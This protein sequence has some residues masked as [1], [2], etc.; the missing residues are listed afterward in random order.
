MRKGKKFKKLLS[1]FLC[2]SMAA[3]TLTAPLTASA[4]VT[5]TA[6]GTVTEKGV[7]LNWNKHTRDN[8][9]GT[10]TL[11]FSA[12]A[13]VAHIAK[14]VDVFTNEK[15]Y[16]TVPEDG[17]YI[18]QAWGSDGGKGSD[19][20]V[21]IVGADIK[22]GGHGGNAGYVEGTFSLKKG[23]KLAYNIGSN[24]T[25][26]NQTGTGGGING[27][28]GSHG[29]SGSYGVGG[30]GG[31]TAVFVYDEGEE[32]TYK[33]TDDYI[34]IAGGGGG[35]GAGHSSQTK[36]PDGGDAGN[37]N[38]SAHAALTA[39]QNNGVA[40]TYYAGSNG[41]SNSD[42]DEYIGY[43]ATNEPGAANSSVWGW[44]S[45][46]SGNDWLGTYDTSRAGG[47]GGNGN[48]RG[49]AGGAG[50]AGGSGGV[51]R[52]IITAWDCGGGGG[53]SSFIAEAAGAVNEAYRSYMLDDNASTTGGSVAI[54][55]VLDNLDKTETLNNVTISGSIGDAFEFVTDGAEEMEISGKSFTINNQNLEPTLL[56]SSGSVSVELTVKPIDGFAGGNAVQLLKGIEISNEEYNFNIE[57]K[58]DTDYVNVPWK[59]TVTA[60]TIYAEP[61][62]TLN[63]SD[64]YAD[65]N[66]RDKV[67][68]DD[69]FAY[70]KEITDYS[71]NG[72]TEATFTALEQTTRYT[73]SYTITAKNEPSKVGTPVGGTISATAVVDVS[74][75]AY[76]NVDGSRNGYKKTLKYNEDGTYD[77]VIEHS[78]GA[79]SGIGSQ[80]SYNETMEEVGTYTT[81]GTETYTITEDG[82][83][84]ILLR[85][86][87]GGDGGDACGDLWNLGS[88]GGAHRHGYGGAGADGGYAYAL[89]KFKANDVLNIT[90]GANGTD[91]KIAEGFTIL[92]D[93]P[94]ES[95]GGTAGNSTAVE[96][97]GN[98]I[99]IAS[100]GAGGGGAY[101]LNIFLTTKTDYYGHG[102]A[103]AQGIT[104]IKDVMPEELPVSTNGTNGSQDGRST[105]ENNMAYAAGTSGN[106]SIFAPFAVEN[107]SSADPNYKTLLSSEK[108]QELIA[109][110]DIPAVTERAHACTDWK[111]TDT[112]TP[113]TAPADTLAKAH[114]E[115]TKLKDTAGVKIYKIT[116]EKTETE[117]EGVRDNLTLSGEISKYFTIKNIEVTGASTSE[118]VIVNGADGAASTFEIG[119][120]IAYNKDTDVVYTIKLEPRTGFLGGNDVP[121]L[122]TDGGCP[123]GLKLTRTGITE[124]ATDDSADLEAKDASD[125]ANVAIADYDFGLTTHDKTIVKGDSVKVSELYDEVTP[126]PAD[127]KADFVELKAELEG[128][129]GAT[130]VSPAVTTEYMLSV[131]LAP[132]TENT[133]AVVA[134]KAQ[135]VK[136]SKPATVY[137][138]YSVTY[139]VKNITPSYTANAQYHES[140][141]TILN[142]GGYVMPDAISVKMGGTELPAT[143]YS[144]DKTT[145]RV[146]INENV[147]EDNITI[148]ATATV[149]TYALIYNLYD[150]DGELTDTHTDYYEIGAAIDHTWAEN[151]AAEAN[152][153][154]DAGYTFVWKWN[155]SDEK[156][157]DKMPGYSVSVDGYYDKIQYT[158]TINYV[159]ENGATAES[160]YSK[161]YTWG[162]AYSVNSP[163]IS[164][165]IADQ[166]TVS[167]TMPK[168]NKTVTVTYSEIAP[169]KYP[170][171][172]YYKYENG[173]T[174]A[175]T[176]SGTF[177][178]GASYSVNSPEITGYI[179]SP[180]LV[181][182]TMT[183]DG[184]TV[185]VTYREDITEVTVSFDAQ[186]GSLA[187]SDTSKTVYCG[188]GRNYGT[189]PTPVK[190]N[191][192][193]I[194][195]FTEAEDGTQ[196]TS[197]TVVTNSSN[198][199]LY[200]HWQGITAKITYDANGGKFTE[201]T[202]VTLDGTYGETY[203]VPSEDPKY[204]GYEFTGWYTDKAAASK[205]NTDAV[206]AYNSPR[207]LYAGW[208]LVDSAEVKF[209]EGGFTVKKYT[210]DPGTTL[211]AEKVT[212]STTGGYFKGWK[213]EDD[214]TDILILD[215]YEKKQGNNSFS[216]T[217]NTDE[218]QVFEKKYAAFW[219]SADDMGKAGVSN[220]KA[221]AVTLASGK[222]AIRFLA[223]ID[224]DFSTYTR[225]GF[226][227]T[228]DCPTPTVEA[229]YQYSNQTKIYKKVYAM[230]TD[231]TTGWLDLAYLKGNTF[232]FDNGAG[233]L[234][235]NLVIKSGN[236]EEIY[237][238][239][240]YIVNAD[241]EYVYGQTRAISYNQ[242]KEYD[243]AVKNQE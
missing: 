82:Y 8:G 220:A 28:G 184:K 63:T 23:Q 140:Y 225:A 224:G 147:I 40:G 57:E 1:A 106:S 194:G 116:R 14:N 65:D 195:W 31:Y 158:L 18:I 185:T 81:A 73:V 151:Y 162:Q 10:Y 139:N 142:G 101:G 134:Q 126:L 152:K 178:A 74:G 173:T 27:D 70:I 227:I 25:T 141:T 146:H 19:I 217:D 176:Y 144:Y 12:E 179:A 75:K 76:V 49:G 103:A 111:E 42:S 187:A 222:N 51:Q 61:G 80:V 230:K 88:R 207:T 204:T 112:V 102:Y 33:H 56:R 235:T 121:V 174:A 215:Y 164:G 90:V 77:L 234:Y 237:Y 39:E 50:F 133:K 130:E 22:E 37:M 163:Q 13:E 243:A 240:P 30:G 114:K 200:A 105:D 100:G 156:P 172:I 68:T 213:A 24:G 6:G 153:T 17:D 208:K 78:I 171:V 129:D 143:S 196:V 35:G 29:I 135:S 214:E 170:L 206:F 127:W 221:Q 36:A 34:L 44:L 219:H 95:L 241:G 54:L 148:S 232:S 115:L 128:T 66:N 62:Q 197:S 94:A 210:F 92:E 53:G 2:A 124:D 41:K 199:T 190:N 21:A 123:T 193:F 198:H 201:G 136:E 107:F 60:N 226:V 161:K 169:E 43:G 223:L 202:T 86:G 59:H 98:Y 47:A 120:I 175:P 182:G 209:S 91:Q 26:T 93:A 122:A 145:G 149:Q 231:G 20:N 83:Y 64:L 167:G 154:A 3:G 188:N 160:S 180:T 16:Y 189:L 168:E 104:E 9:D 84:L 150:K 5:A 155:T 137:V 157:L 239:T 236:E 181:S 177:E 228:K 186:G 192:R 96:Y 67:G 87:D 117:L 79:E 38:T 132:K 216:V 97:D 212:P 242:L 191:S 183:T 69:N 4:A 205:F 211:T 108:F 229:G 159:Y 15:G 138:E 89:G 55:P 109:I 58:A 119:N 233:L 46:G 32:V 238:A 113:K 48:G 165:Y 99:A 166:A 218:T 45:T 72:I 85:G 203:P 131:E 71:V 125:Y 11:I 7:S 118:P 52:N 110:E